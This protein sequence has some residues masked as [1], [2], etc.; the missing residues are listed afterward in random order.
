MAGFNFIVHNPN[1]NDALP[2]SVD[3]VTLSVQSW[4]AGMA[5]KLRIKRRYTVHVYVEGNEQ[6][7]NLTLTLDAQEFTE[8]DVEEHKTV[9][10]PEA[11][12]LFPEGDPPKS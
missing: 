10:E 3:S 9:I 4:E 8:Y 12:P 7:E 6:L 5:E 11:K 1:R 2:W